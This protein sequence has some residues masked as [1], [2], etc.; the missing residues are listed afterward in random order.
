MK[1]LRRKKSILKRF[2]ISYLLVLMFMVILLIPIYNIMINSV[3]E[4]AVTETNHR[5]DSGI[6]SLNSSIISINHAVYNL[7][8]N[9]DIKS[10]I[11]VSEP[12]PIDYY[13]MTKA[14]KQFRAA[15]E[16]FQIICN[17]LLMTKNNEIAITLDRIYDDRDLMYN[18]YITYNGLTQEKWMDYVIN[19]CRNKTFMPETVVSFKGNPTREVLTYFLAYNSK[20]ASGYDSTFSILIDKEDI[21]RLLTTSEAYQNGWLYIQNLNG[22]IILRHHYDADPITVVEGKKNYL[23]KI[24]G[25]DTTVFVRDAFDT[26]IR[27]VLGVPAS[28]Y[29]ADINRARNL[30]IMYFLLTLVV[31]GVVSLLMSY[32][33]S[34]PIMK[35]VS[36]ID[37]KGLNDLDNRGEYDRILNA[38]ESLFQSKE[39]L[40][41]QLESNKKGM[42][43]GLFERLLHSAI[44]I[45]AELDLINKYINFL[46]E[47]YSI[48]NIRIGNGDYTKESYNSGNC[49]TDVFRT[50]LAVFLR[51]NYFSTEFIHI[52]GDANIIVLVKTNPDTNDLKAVKKK[53]EEVQNKIY[54]DFKLVTFCGI[55]NIHSGFIELSEAFTESEKALNCIIGT[56]FVS[57][58]LYS[59][60]NSGQFDMWLDI[61]DNTRLFQMLIA[62]DKEKVI[63]SLAVIFERSSNRILSNVWYA[64]QLYYSLRGILITAAREISN[65]VVINSP[66]NYKADISVTENFDIITDQMIDFCEKVQNSHRSKNADLKNSIIEYINNN[67]SD[68]NLYARELSELFNVS[69]KYMYNLVKER[70][71][72]SLSNYVEKVRLEKAIE[73]MTNTD[74]SIAT[75]ATSCGFVSQNTFYKAFKRVYAVSPSTWRTIHQN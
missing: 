19:D 40:Y 45:E 58:I 53:T 25:E 48:L 64:K 29:A 54:R 33:N 43:A 62:G 11:N 27:I 36:L 61:N 57:R 46:P 55:S 10:I 9:D 32:Y 73:K 1:L 75:I 6:E 50:M 71:G 22:G 2:L 37:R 34:K 49:D 14:Q 17:S 5:L 66:V 39:S 28:S 4:K 72:M 8:S 69:E 59:E 42:I 74:L 44:Y 63:E 67:Y 30:V 68:V 70:T 18:D 23:S 65:D 7:L 35:I 24:N 51:E 15:I 52:T 60:I 21:L 38:I 47:N 16:P 31:G 3:S 20:K 13:Y 56:P 12:N 26:G 41:Q